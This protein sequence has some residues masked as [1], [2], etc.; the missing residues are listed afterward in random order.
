M[1]T[2]EGKMYHL[3]TLWDGDRKTLWPRLFSS[4]WRFRDWDANSSNVWV[5]PICAIVSTPVVIPC[6]A[7]RLRID[8]RNM[9]AKKNTS[10]IVNSFISPFTFIFKEKQNLH[11]VYMTSILARNDCTYSLKF[12]ICYLYLILAVSCS[13]L[14]IDLPDLA[15]VVCDTTVGRSTSN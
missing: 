7:Y 13:P 8:M 9:R 14:Q 5:V 4:N 6:A 3:L 11:I 1:K 12:T 2:N 15:S 10:S